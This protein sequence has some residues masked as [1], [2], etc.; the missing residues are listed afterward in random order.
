MSLKRELPR[1][2]N[3]KIL[4]STLGF[5]P[6]LLVS[7]HILNFL[8]QQGKLKSLEFAIIYPE[9]DPLPEQLIRAQEI[10]KQKLTALKTARLAINY[11]FYPL[12]I[13]QFKMAVLGVME[14]VGSY[15]KNHFAPRKN[16]LYFNLSG[17]MNVLILCC[18]VAATYCPTNA[19][20]TTIENT[21]TIRHLEINKAVPLLNESRYA[22]LKTFSQT[23]ELKN[24]DEITRQIDQP[25]K[26]RT[27]IYRL[28]KKMVAENLLEEEIYSR[29]SMKYRLSLHGVCTVK[30]IE[31]FPAYYYFPLQG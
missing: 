6:E 17:G 16:E 27:T 23:S 30:A 2:G 14:I 13:E 26:D 4:I 10:I 15:Y 18:Q 7:E 19:V 12:N 1:E 31:T 28:V 9:Q 22:I 24:F 5:T 21:T 25:K 29:K 8:S 11:Q 20:F 3:I